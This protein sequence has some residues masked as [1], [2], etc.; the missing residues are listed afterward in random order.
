MNPSFQPEGVL[1]SLLELHLLI[2]RAEINA[3]KLSRHQ[4][5]QD[6]ARLAGGVVLSLY[7]RAVVVVT[8][9]FEVARRVFEEI[10]G[11]AFPRNPSG[12]I[13][14]GRLTESPVAEAIG[15]NLKEG[16]FIVFTRAHAAPAFDSYSWYIYAS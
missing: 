8:R 9:H 13:A 5:A 6:L 1:L 2:D 10:K 4:G 7:F 15:D 12:W 16:Y 14:Y 11:D 3:F